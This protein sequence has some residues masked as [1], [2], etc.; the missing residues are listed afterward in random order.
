MSL[1][2]FLLTFIDFYI[3]TFGLLFLIDLIR[4]KSKSITDYIFAFF[5]LFISIAFLFT[6]IIK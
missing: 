6:Y 2:N 1:F 3:F 4:N 5:V